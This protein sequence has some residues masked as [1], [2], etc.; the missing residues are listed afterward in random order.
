MK[1]YSVLALFSVFFLARSEE[2]QPAAEAVVEVS[3][4]S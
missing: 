1:I 2:V 3:E 4:V